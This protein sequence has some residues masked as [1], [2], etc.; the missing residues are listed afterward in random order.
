[1]FFRRESQKSI[2]VAMV[3]S[4]G[5]DHFGVQES[6]RAHETHEVTAMAIRPVHH[7]RN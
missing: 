1:M 5:R 2:S 4:R 3:D 6:G 7:W